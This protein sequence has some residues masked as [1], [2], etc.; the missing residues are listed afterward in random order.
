M[1]K[2]SSTNKLREV[3]TTRD[4]PLLQIG[5]INGRFFILAGGD[6][7]QMIETLLSNDWYGKLLMMS[8]HTST[9]RD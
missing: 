9:C 5:C 8:Y 4:T 2:L 7:Q 6:I 1:D 3:M